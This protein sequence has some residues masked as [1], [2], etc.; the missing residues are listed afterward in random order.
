MV[1]SSIFLFLRIMHI[2]VGM[3]NKQDF[4]IDELSTIEDR[5]NIGNGCHHSF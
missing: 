2:C 4:P 5:T 3:H 1:G